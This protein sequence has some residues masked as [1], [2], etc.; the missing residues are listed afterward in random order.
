MTPR[1]NFISKRRPLSAIFIGS[2]PSSPNLP[3]LPEPPSPGASSNASGLPSPP[4]TNS[5]GSDSTGGKSTNGGSLRRRSVSDTVANMENGRHGESFSAQSGRDF[6]PDEDD[7]NDEDHTAKLTGGRRRSAQTSTENAMALQRVLSLTQRN[8][9]ALDKL[10]SMSRLNTPSPTFS[11]A[12]SSRSPNPPSGAP[13]SSSSSSSSRVTSH[14]HAHSFPTGRHGENTLS[15]SE[16][17][18]ESHQSYSHSSDDQSATPPSTISHTSASMRLRRISL[19]ESPHRPKSRA[20]SPQTQRTPRKRVSLVSAPDRSSYLADDDE[21]DVT[22]SA[23]AALAS[24]RR[25]P[26]GSNGKKSRQ[27]LPRE[28]TSMS[29]SDGRASQEP[30]TPHNAS[31]RA[32]EH[33]SPSPKRGTTRL[34]EAIQLSPQRGQRRVS[35]VRDLTRRHQTR[36]LSEDLNSMS[37]EHEE[38][39]DHVLGR[40]QSNRSG[41]MENSLGTR[42]VGD[43]LRAAG[44][45]MRKDGDDIFA[46]K[47]TPSTSHRQRHSSEA[48]VPDWDDS[49]LQARSTS[50]R[51]NG[52]SRGSD[53]VVGQGYDLRTPA[54]NS[55]SRQHERSMTGGHVRPATSMAEFP[56]YREGVP[57]RTAPPALRSYKS[58]Y[59][60]RDREGI[61]S[62]TVP[63]LQQYSSLVSDQPPL[64][65]PQFNERTYGSPRVRPRENT[66]TQDSANGRPPSALED[67]IAEHTRLMND[68]LSI[69]ESQLSRL[70]L[71]GDT[72]TATVP[73]LFRDAQSLVRLAG[74]V[75]NQLRTCMNRAL[76]RQI[77]AE[78]DGEGA[79]GVDMVQLWQ[80]VGSD[81]R[82]CMRCSDELVRT[83]SGFM[84]GTGKILRESTAIS[85]SGQTLQH[86]RTGS[87]D[88][89]AAMAAADSRSSTSGTGSGKGSAKGGS[90]I[91]GRRS[92]DS[93]RSWDAVRS[94]RDGAE[95]VRKV[96]SRTEH[97]ASLQ[98]RGEPGSRMASV[99]S[100]SELMPPPP[101]PA[102]R[103]PPA[104]TIAPST[105]MRRVIT[106][107][108]SSRQREPSTPGGYV[109]LPTIPSQ[110]YLDD[111]DPSPTP[112][113]RQH[114]NPPGERMRGLPPLSIPTPLP[115]L[116]SESQLSRRTTAPP[117]TNSR[118]VSSNSSMTVRPPPLF[119]IPP[120]P[121]ATT[122]I[123]P[124]TVSNN[125]TPPDKMS[126]VARTASGS[127][128][129]ASTSSRRN[130]VTFSRSTVSAISGLQ[131]RD[132]RKRTTSTTSSGEEHPVKVATPIGTSSP[133]LRVRPVSD[134]ERAG[135]SRPTLGRRTLAARTRSS[136]DVQSDQEH[137][138]AATASTSQAQ[139]MRLPAK[140]ERRRTITEIFS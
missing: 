15:G 33:T 6:S 52:S 94:G 131:G 119:N 10:S 48:A 19:P 106:A 59:L 35:T 97:R 41:S 111:V 32:I 11:R 78:V 12:S 75:N 108:D 137:W 49:P 71:M 132:V 89:G 124:H 100:D 139:T 29:G 118:K 77:D 73:G 117:G 110:E 76:E 83:L 61:G 126:S 34:R 136:L 63:R 3:D 24:M 98:L 50:S 87:L 62:N 30:S 104:S 42:L 68:S 107:R 36:W 7:G 72:T 121:S 127:S 23:M 125:I 57:P 102:P 45:T 28:F 116:P 40:R 26:T 53:R 135:L 133:S 96:S 105:S 14:S 5:T 37:P 79:E 85:S 113:T 99:P 4:A 1:P 123:T 27:P 130:N 93:R 70:P 47:E 134:T 114:N 13:S 43:S 109:E 129:S 140:K 103:P 20:S 16:T 44:I 66:I 56:T 101:I 65:A 38:Y 91:D 21:P 69:F 46:T 22:V 84:L 88:S 74:E 95:V 112:L 122:A 18:R 54:N 120:T 8:R 60:D 90:G 51:L 58:T 86:L 2:N 81:F 64:R 67:A 31:Y 138:A 55:T 9:M 25:S 115:S 82:D 80:D 128:A 39:E 17:E 92:A